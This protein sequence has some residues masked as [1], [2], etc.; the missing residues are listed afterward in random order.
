MRSRKAALFILSAALFF[1]A[2]S[3]AHA[4]KATIKIINKSKWEI[5]HLYLS[6]TSE[7]HWGPDQLGDDVLEPGDSF[8]LSKIDCDDYDI[9]VVDEDGDECVIE[10]QSLCNDDSVWK[11][12]S[13]EL[14]SCENQ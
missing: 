5:H 10:E 12:T 6:P 8:T 3:V 9:K 11:I 14:L 7:R 1:L 2:P 4:K 13:D